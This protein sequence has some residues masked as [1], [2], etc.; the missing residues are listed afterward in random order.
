MKRSLAEE[1]FEKYSPVDPSD[2]VRAFNSRFAELGFIGVSVIE[3]DFNE[4]GDT[5]VTFKDDENNLLDIVFT[6]DE[7]GGVVALAPG[8]E[9]SEWVT[10]IELDALAPPVE[11]SAF[12]QYA[13]LT[14]LKWLNT[15][16]LEAILMAGDLEYNNLDGDDL[17][18]KVSG[19]YYQ[20]G[21]MTVYES[22]EKID[23]RKVSVIR[24]GKKVRLAIVRRKR[25]KLLTGRQKSS[26]RS[27]VRKRKMHKNVIKRKRLKSLRIR[28]RMGIKTP[29]LSKNQKV[30]GGANRPRGK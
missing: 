19:V 17:D 24:G 26:I 6:F 20:M 10:V 23:E 14:N 3:A 11:Q 12:G 18:G 15:S 30:Q 4:E 21:N 27:A 7:D 25:K 8:E 1:L 22:F 9:D 16:A 29:K 5:F 13:N 28:K 2:V